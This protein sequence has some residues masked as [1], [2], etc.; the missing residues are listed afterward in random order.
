MAYAVSRRTREIGVRMALGARRADI[1]TLIFSESLTLTLLGILL[2]L[3]GAY[4]ITRVLNSLLFGVSSTDPFTFAAV[5]LLL[6]FA[7][8]LASCIPA[9]RATRVDPLTALRYE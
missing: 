3:V 4:A 8:L 9:L 7:S 1:L 2:G 5:T 6:G